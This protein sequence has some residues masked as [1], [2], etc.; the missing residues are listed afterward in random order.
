MWYFVISS[1]TPFLH[2]SCCFLLAKGVNVD[3]T[4]F[5][6]PRNT[7]WCKCILNLFYTYSSTS[8]MP[9]VVVIDAV[10]CPWCICT[11]NPTDLCEVVICY[12]LSTPGG[13]IC[14]FQ[15]AERWMVRDEGQFNPAMRLIRHVD[16]SATHTHTH[17]YIMISGKHSATR[18]T[19]RISFLSCCIQKQ[20]L[21]AYA[22][23]CA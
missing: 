6:H 21:Y 13:W 2:L 5:L 4:P 17:T 12:S 20:T 8:V 22:N 16:H 9:S 10:Q 3:I 19:Y 15:L 7:F 11:A 1:N 18:L 23:L 14:L